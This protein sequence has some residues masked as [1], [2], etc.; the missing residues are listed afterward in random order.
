ML[1]VVTLHVLLFGMSYYEARVLISKGFITNMI[2]ALCYKL[3]AK[4][5]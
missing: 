4:K 2:E 5:P 3:V 1:I